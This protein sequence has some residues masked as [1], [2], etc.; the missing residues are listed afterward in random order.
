MYQHHHQMEYTDLT[1]IQWLNSL[2]GLQITQQLLLQAE[3]LL[4]THFF[5]TVIYRVLSN[6]FELLIHPFV[7]CRR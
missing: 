3:A 4:K 1:I 2:E 5:E 6:M 7:H